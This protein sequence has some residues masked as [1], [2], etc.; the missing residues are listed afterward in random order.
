MR[1]PP[2]GQWVL[3]LGPVGWHLSRLEGGTPSGQQ[4]HRSLQPTQ[5]LTHSCE[6]RP[7]VVNLH[8][9]NLCDQGV[10]LYRY[11]EGRA[12]FPE[13]RDLVRELLKLGEHEAIQLAQ[14]SNQAR[15]Q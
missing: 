1:S 7:I 14:Q 4:Y 10:D 12:K 13:V 15:D 2:P 8:A 6:A 9:K 3:A 5:S 11:L